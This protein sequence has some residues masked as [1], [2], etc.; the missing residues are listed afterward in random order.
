MPS[1]GGIFLSPPTP[2]LHKFKDEQPTILRGICSFYSTP[3]HPAPSAG[4][5]CQPTPTLHDLCPAVAPAVSLSGCWLF[6]LLSTAG[7][8]N[9]GLV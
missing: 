4:S 5:T 2:S 3:P 9:T 7:R 6:P 1:V 8:Q